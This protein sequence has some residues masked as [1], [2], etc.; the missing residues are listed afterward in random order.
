MMRGTIKIDNPMQV[1]CTISITAT[2]EDWSGLKEQLTTD[3]PSW[4]LRGLIGEL[5]M[6]ATKQ[7]VERADLEEPK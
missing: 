7:F 3:Y 2:L 1:E 4:K 5:V 6:K